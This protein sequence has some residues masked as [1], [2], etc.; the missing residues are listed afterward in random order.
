M[1]FLTTN[2]V[3][4]IDDGIA[5]SIHFK[6]KYNNLNLEQ[7]ISIWRGFLEKAATL[8]GAPIYSRADFESLVG[9]ERNGRE[10]VLQG[11]SLRCESSLTF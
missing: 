5:S 8:Q 4:Q 11:Q 7:R 3:E 1:I 10:V 2:R 9:K 6:L